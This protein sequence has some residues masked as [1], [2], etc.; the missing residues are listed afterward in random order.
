VPGPASRIDP[1]WTARAEAA[2]VV[3]AL[4]LGLIAR[5]FPS[6]PLWLDEALSVNIADRPLA[7]IPDALRRDGHPPLYYA[8]LHGWISLFGTSDAAV[9]SLSVLFGVLAVGLVFV[10]ARRHGGL[11]LARPAVVLAAVLPYAVRYSS[12]TRMYSM[13]MVLSLVGWL[14]ADRALERP[15]RGR[16]VGLAI[17]SGAAMLTHYWMIFLAAAAVGLLALRRWRRP[18]ARRSSLLVGGAVAAGGVLFLPW[19]GGFLYQRA[20]T[21]T[22]WAPPSRPTRVVTESLV[23]FSGGY[24]PEALLLLAV[25]A[26]LLVLG[27]LGRR[28]RAGLVLGVPTAAW[29]V[30]LTWLV[31]ATMAVGAAASVVGRSAFAGRYAAGYFPFVAVLAAA[32]VAVL[33]RGWLRVGVLATVMALSAIGVLYAFDR[34]RT[35]AGVIAAVLVAEA[36]PGDVVV[37]CPDQL[38]PSLSRVVRDDVEVLRYPDLGDPRLVDWVDY[39][40]RYDATDPAEVAQRVLARVPAERT[41]WVNYSSG[42]RV[43]DTQCDR[44]IDALAVARPV[45]ALLETPDGKYFEASALRRFDPPRP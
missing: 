31:A 19:V 10:V 37:V 5:L 26:V 25:L 41:L 2:L 33:G 40:Q 17:V 8:L 18:E 15:T 4:A 27:V 13:L 3:A 42:Y 11:E 36:R 29:T 12:E 30:R 35:Q 22:P 23:D 32:G 45:T 38:G 16:L 9:R 1:R 6:T 20:H 44:L 34:D 39:Q 7:D 43:V 24:D 21:G 14:L 28:E